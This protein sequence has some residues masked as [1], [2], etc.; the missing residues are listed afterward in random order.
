MIYISKLFIIEP[1]ICWI[2]VDSDSNTVIFPVNK[3]FNVVNNFIPKPIGVHKKSN[4]NFNIKD[5]LD[6]FNIDLSFKDGDL[7]A[8][9]K[10]STKY[11][12]VNF[13]AKHQHNGV[14]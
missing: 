10:Y 1:P 7:I 4:V 5:D 2:T 12:E 6:I 8:D 9:L 13:Y 3:F 14:F 11:A